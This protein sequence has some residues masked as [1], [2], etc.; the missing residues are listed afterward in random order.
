MKYLSGEEIQK[1]DNV[2]IKN[3][4]T[5]GVVEYII[6]TDQERREWNLDETGVL[7]ASEPFGTVFWPLDEKDDPVVFVSRANT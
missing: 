3:R 2:L 7:L 1:G 5:L 4:R 6:E